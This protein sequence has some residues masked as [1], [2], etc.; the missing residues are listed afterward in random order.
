MNEILVTVA[1]FFNSLFGTTNRQSP[2]MF[3]DYLKEYAREFSSDEDEEEDGRE[4]A[5]EEHGYFAGDCRPPI[6]L[7]NIPHVTNFSCS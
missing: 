1:N 3:A 7:V 6:F 4:S 5:H 2:I